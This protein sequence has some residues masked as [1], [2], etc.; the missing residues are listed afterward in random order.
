MHSKQ[1]K[2]H[3]SNLTERQL[4]TELIWE[5]RKQAKK[6]VKGYFKMGYH[7]LST[8]SSYPKTE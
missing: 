6:S 1:D 8:E 2:N 7:A 4:Q 5:G 3:T